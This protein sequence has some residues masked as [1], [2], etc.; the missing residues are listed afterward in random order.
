MARVKKEET[1]QKWRAQL[2]SWEASGL[3]LRAFA[4]REGININT[5]WAWKK[6]LRGTSRAMPKF[7]PLSVTSTAKLALLEVVI[8][9]SVVVRVGAD[10]DEATLT[11]LTR[12]ARALGVSR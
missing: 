5:L 8:G 10:F 3:S 11:R 9:E 7:A 4:S 12:W 1:E 6:R 2:E